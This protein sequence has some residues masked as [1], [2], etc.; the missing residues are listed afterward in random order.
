MSL[1]NKI[2]S[3]EINEEDISE[4]ITDKNNYDLQID[5][6]KKEKKR[7]ESVV[8]AAEIGT[9]EWE[10]KTGNLVV[11]EKWAAMVGYSLKELAPISV[12]TWEKLSH[13]EDLIKS[14]KMLE[15]VFNKKIPYY[16]LEVRVKHKWQLDLGS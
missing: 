2:L 1:E 11:N 16:E 5:F 6:L 12:K 8:D 13:P 3:T 7:L 9:W 14:N 10:V 4:L 15:F